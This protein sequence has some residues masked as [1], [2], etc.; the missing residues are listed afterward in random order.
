LIR[1]VDTRIGLM[2][3]FAGCFT[4]YRDRDLTEH[5]VEK[6]VG[7]RIY[8]LAL[9]Y[10]DLN[11]HEQLRRDPLLDMLVEK[12]EPGRELLHFKE[13]VA[14]E[15]NA[16]TQPISCF[17]ELQIAD[18]LPL[19]KAYIH[20]IQIGHLITEKEEEDTPP[21]DVDNAQHPDRTACGNYTVREIE[22]PRLVR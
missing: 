9:G 20:S 17:V 15:E 10:E 13:E 18:H 16:C 14:D 11:D 22:R 12:R 7:Q 21:N 3:R 5:G 8:G 4:D 6:L 19:C 1:E 2:Q